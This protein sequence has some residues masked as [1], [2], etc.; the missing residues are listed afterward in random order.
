MNYKNIILPTLSMWLIHV[1]DVLSTQVVKYSKL[2]FPHEVN[3]WSLGLILCIICN[4][5]DLSWW[6]FSWGDVLWVGLYYFKFPCTLTKSTIISRWAS[7]VS[8][9]KPLEK[10]AHPQ[11]FFD[12]W[13]HSLLCRLMLF[14]WA[15]W[16]PYGQLPSSYAVDYWVKFEA[17]MNIQVVSGKTP[18]LGQL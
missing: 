3:L 9:C 5:C 16:M 1:V 8:Q 12:S 17:M 14:Q 18:S 15:P 7:W 6:S 4:T 10:S 13:M 2:I 11:F